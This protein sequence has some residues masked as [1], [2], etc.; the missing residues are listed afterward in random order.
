MASQGGIFWSSDED[1][2]KT[3]RFEEVFPEIRSLA[4][5]IIEQGSGNAGLGAR[6]FSKNSVREFINCSSASCSG[7]GFWL[8]RL[9]RRMV[10]DGRRRLHVQ[11]PCESRQESGT[12]CLNSFD[13][14]IAL[15]FIL[16]DVRDTD[17]PF[18]LLAFL[19]WDHDW[20]SHHFPAASLSHA[21]DL[22]RQGGVGTVRLDFLW[23]DLE[24]ERGR[25]TWKKYD[26]IIEALWARGLCVL[27]VLQYNPD[28]RAGP[29]NQAPE[30]AE[31]LRYAREVVRRF[32]RKI[33]YWE[34]WNEPDHP[35]YWQPQDGLTAYASLLAKASAAIRAEDATAQ[36]LLGGLSQN[37]SANLRRIYE[38]AG[39]DAFDIVNIHP[40]ANPLNDDALAFV[41][42]TSRECVDVMRAFSDGEKPIWITEIGCP[43]VA[44]DDIKSWWLGANPSE[45]EQAQW[46]EKVYANM[47]GW[48]NVER[49]FWAFFRD[50]PQHFGDGV[51]YFG[52]IRQDFSLKPAFERYQT[53][54]SKLRGDRLS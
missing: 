3:F 47:A 20:N 35:N 52:L 36:V 33:R 31:Y 42:R 50:T 13:V 29:G 44:R 24:A 48:P 46:L 21:A 17:S 38:K 7:I 19:H 5:E 22:V 6:R 32:R 45:A 34:V 30:E 51:D 53:L 11:A 27:G 54:S 10:R 23:S 12:P 49:V 18:G 8:G 16:P 43:G 41:E 14:R 39:R 25:F 15:E 9:L 40:F 4:V 26:A 37:I 1:R 28:W 2:G